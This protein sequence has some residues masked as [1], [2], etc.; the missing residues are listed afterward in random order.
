[1]GHE[2]MGEVVE[3][4][5]ENKKVKVGDRVVVPFTICLRRMRPVPARQFLGLRANQPQQGRRR[6]G[7]RPYH[8]GAVRLH[9]PD[10]RLSRRPGRVCPGALCR[11]R[12]GKNSE[13]ADRRAGAVP[14]RHLPDRMAGGRAM[15]HRADRY[16]RDLGRRAG[17]AD[18]DPQ[19]HPARRE[20]GDRDRPLA[21][22]AQHGE[23]G[24]GHH[25]Q[26]R[27]GERRRTAQRA[28]PR[29]G[30]GEMHRRGRARGARLRP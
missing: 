14:R 20:A 28:D 29:Q 9:A 5:R 4:G 8:R 7:V 22:A 12:A 11:R 30:A 17:R 15:R 27:G 24:R 25:D 19:R 23:G 26:F 18:R 6:Q 10:R 13:R 21:R 16:G 2:F 3:V 1:M